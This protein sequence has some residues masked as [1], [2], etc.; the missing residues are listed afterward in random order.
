MSWLTAAPNLVTTEQTLDP[1]DMTK[2][3][4]YCNQDG[5]TLIQDI[6]A[7]CKY[8][9]TKWRCCI[10]RFQ[11]GQNET[12]NPINILIVKNNV[13]KWLSYCSFLFYWPTCTSVGTSVCLTT[14]FDNPWKTGPFPFSHCT[15]G[16]YRDSGGR[17]NSE[18]GCTIVL[19]FLKEVNKSSFSFL[20]HDRGPCR[21]KQQP[22][23]R[24]AN[25][26]H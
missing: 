3:G 2:D 22:G 5:G 10:Q 11:E 14:L 13:K 26:K 15:Y 9:G 18:I 19:W 7:S 20:D 24:N 6:V 8:S 12:Y 25:E 17:F 23:P 1:N 21:L 16:V 4:R